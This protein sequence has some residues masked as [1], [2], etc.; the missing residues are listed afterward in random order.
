MKTRSLSGR[1]KE[2]LSG[3]LFL[4]PSFVLFFVFLL[5]P[6]VYGLV[7]CFTDYGGFNLGF[8]FVGID[9]Y[10]RLFSDDYFKISMGNNLF[11][12]VTFVPATVVLSIVFAVALN[13]V[14]IFRKF[15]RMAFYFPQVAS[16]VSVA[17]VWCILFN[18]TT[19]PINAAL[20][21]LGVRNPPEWLMSQSWAM[22]AVVIVSVWKSVGFYMIILLAGLQGIPD[23]LY[24]SALIDG[25]GAWNRTRYITL[26]MLTPTIFMV[27]ILAVI[28]SFQVFDLVSV[29]TNGGPGRATNVLV[30]RIYQEAF[31]NLN[32][33]YASAMAAVLF[34][35]VFAITA[36]Q[37]GLEKK[38]VHY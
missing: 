19:G 29:M 7:I 5:V 12:L 3:Y 16:M 25:A 2:N 33:G 28:N 11:Y 1:T 10:R 31:V 32:V 4:L 24:E 22:V 20:T 18:P 30:Y 26:P 38:W 9:N 6:L 21:H 13:G 14:R 8:R 23:Y 15:L 37:F 17:M 36:L 35:I 27:T 34:I